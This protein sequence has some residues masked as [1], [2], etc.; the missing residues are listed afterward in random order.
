MH[1]FADDL[2]AR[3][4]SG[5]EPNDRLAFRRAAEN[6]LADLPPALVGEG[7]AW[8]AIEPVWRS[9]FHP[10]KIRRTSWNAGIAT[11]NRRRRKT[12]A[13]GHF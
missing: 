1:A 12:L 5:L 6:A 2:I 11:G 3:L 9:Y 8:R 4:E 10:E 7:S 13:S